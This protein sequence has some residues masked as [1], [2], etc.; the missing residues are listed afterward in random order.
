[1]RQA[2]NVN[3][4]ILARESRGINQSE[5][6]AKI[7]FAPAFMSKLERCEAPISEE[8]LNAISNITQYPVSFFYQNGEIAPESIAYRKRET[9]AQKVLT[10]VNARVNI[11]R[12]HVKILSEA[13]NVPMP[14]IPTIQVTEA[15]TAAKIAREVR[16]A[17]D[18]KNGV[19]ENVVEIVERNG[20]AVRTIDL[21]TERVDS[22]TVLTDN[23]YP[24]IILNKILLGD[25][26]RFS[27]AYQLGHLVMHTYKAVDWNVD[28]SHEANLF[29]AEF[30]MPEQ[31]MREEF[32]NGV[33]LALLAELKRKWKVSMISLMYRADDLGFLT[34][35]QKRYLIQQFNDKKIRRRE[36]VELDAPIEQPKIFRQWIAEVKKRKKLDV[37]GIAE[38]LHLH[39]DEFIQQYG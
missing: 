19:I 29:A 14:I 24:V 39:T 21:G 16:R 13:L 28:V 7:G 1:M 4:V 32:N 27:L 18:L 33:T 34:D 30:L 17:W 8:H 11:V 5:L 20:I 9:V 26:Q 23:K 3:M 35:N 37:A 31:E 2:I 15:M 12:L 6:A 36:P 25:R 10:V 38:E 22:R